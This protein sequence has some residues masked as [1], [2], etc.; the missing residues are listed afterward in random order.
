MQPLACREWEVFPHA[1]PSSENPVTVTDHE[2]WFPTEQCFPNQLGPALQLSIL[3]RSL[4]AVDLEATLELCRGVSAFLHNDATWI[5]QHQLPQRNWR[6]EEWCVYNHPSPNLLWKGMALALFLGPTCL[7]R[8]RKASR[9][10]VEATCHKLRRGLYLQNHC[11]FPRDCIPVWRRKSSVQLHLWELS[12]HYNSFTIRV[13]WM[14]PKVFNS[15][16]IFLSTQA[17]LM[18]SLVFHE[19][20][21][22]FPFPLAKSSHSFP[23]ALKTCIWA[24]IW[25]L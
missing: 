21:L 19:K 6:Q 11:V 20:T 5:Q 9:E 23:A 1:W 10:V 15:G 12:W 3:C 24:K 25:F 13:V 2:I 14:W 17:P 7:P 16:A 22:I 4:F 8:E 18:F